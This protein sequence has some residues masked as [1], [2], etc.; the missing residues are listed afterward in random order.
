MPIGM[1]DPSLAPRLEHTAL[2][3]AGASGAALTYRVEA[4]E[5][6]EGTSVP[7]AE[8]GTASFDVEPEIEPAHQEMPGAILGTF[9]VAIAGAAAGWWLSPRLTEMGEPQTWVLVGT[10]LGLL[11]AWL[12]L[13]WTR[14]SS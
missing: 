1:D 5:V 11:V 4:S 3:G 13:R 12:G 14:E 6:N 7:E 8:T 9:V 10:M 2:D